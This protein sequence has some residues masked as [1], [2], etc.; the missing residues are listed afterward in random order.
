MVCYI[1]EYITE[2]WFI[3]TSPTNESYKM[4]DDALDAYYKVINEFEENKLICGNFTVDLK[5][6]YGLPHDY[7]YDETVTC[8]KGEEY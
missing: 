4:L 7:S 3:P 8:Y 5:R 2:H 1:I 6:V